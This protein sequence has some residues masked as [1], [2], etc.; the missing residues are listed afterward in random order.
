MYFGIVFSRQARPLNPTKLSSVSHMGI[1]IRSDILSYPIFLCDNISG[2][3]SLSII[4]LYPGTKS[5][6]NQ[7]TSNSCSQESSGEI[8]FSSSTIPGFIILLTSSSKVPTPAEI[9]PP[10]YL[11]SSNLLA[12]VSGRDLCQARKVI[13]FPLWPQL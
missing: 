6:V 9:P 11:S 12:T 10:P 7:F 2:E 13:A 4:Y 5:S 8:L 3:N 1:V